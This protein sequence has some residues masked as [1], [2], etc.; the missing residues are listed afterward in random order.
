MLRPS[1]NPLLYYFR[2]G[3][4]LSRFLL[5]FISVHQYYVIL[6]LNSFPSQIAQETKVEVEPD[7]VD[8]VK[9]KSTSIPIDELVSALRSFRKPL[10][11]DTVGKLKEPEPFTGKDPKC[12]GNC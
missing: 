6:K 8:K 4:L 2:L 3:G 9:D 7:V 11:S 1:P 12:K 5:H 10:K